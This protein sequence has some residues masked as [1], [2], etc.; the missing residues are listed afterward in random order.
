M[1]DPVDELHDDKLQDVPEVADLV[2]AGRKK[3]QRTILVHKIT[4]T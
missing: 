2:N 1:A 3:G 4:I